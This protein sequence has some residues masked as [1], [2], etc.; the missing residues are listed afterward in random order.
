MIDT[1]SNPDV[2]A[3]RQRTGL[4]TGQRA[5]TSRPANS[6]VYLFTGEAGKQAS[7]PQMGSL[8]YES[9]TKAVHINERGFT[10]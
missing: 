7:A 6:A 1:E 5:G 2:H 4:S 9:Y 10:A 8:Q 3:V